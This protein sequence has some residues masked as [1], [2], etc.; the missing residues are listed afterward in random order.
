MV[1]GHIGNWELAGG[2]V[3]AR[4]IPL[5][6]IVRGMANPLFDA[7]INHTREGLG[8]TIVHDSEAVRRTPRS[9]RAGRAVAFVADQGAEGP[10][11]DV[12]SFFRTA[13]QDSSRCRGIRFA[14]RGPGF[15]R[16]CAS[17][18]EWTLSSDRRATRGEAHGRH[19]QRRRRDRRAVH[20]EV[21]AL[22]A[23]SSGA[24]LLAAS[25][26]EASTAGYAGRAARSVGVT[27]EGDAGSQTATEISPR[28]PR[29]H[30]D[31]HR[32]GHDPRRDPGAAGRAPES[33]HH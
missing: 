1:T 30:W 17:E 11:V 24:V 15:V 6:A 14:F 3:A 12:R 13:C 29:A 7:Y 9:L 21:G 31:R 20:G 27:R 10:R 5:D 16:R 26:V 8:M 25:Q 22:G 2:Y 28:Q 32:P 19:G 18:A 33:D 23:R 4:G